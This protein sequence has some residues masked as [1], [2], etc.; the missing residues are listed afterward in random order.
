MVEYKFIQTDSPLLVGLGGVGEGGGERVRRNKTGEEGKGG[1][2]WERKR[3]R[4]KG[5]EDPDVCVI[6]SGSGPRCY[7][8]EK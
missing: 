8:E 2:K 4:R 5:R 7:Y 6:A 3:G 1:G